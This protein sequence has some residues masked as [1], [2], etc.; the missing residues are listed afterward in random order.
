MLVMKKPLAKK[1]VASAGEL[2]GREMDSILIC[3]AFYAGGKERHE[4]TGG[5]VLVVENLKTLIGV[6]DEVMMCHVRTTGSPLL[7]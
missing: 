3:V 4:A 5:G 6:H 2:I 1:S 7:G